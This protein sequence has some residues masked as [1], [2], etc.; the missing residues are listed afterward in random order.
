MMHRTQQSGFSLVEMV[1]YIGLVVLVFTLVL[2]IVFSFSSSYQELGAD[3][4]A[5]QS[6]L[7]SMERMV[8]D[9]HGALDYT[10]AL[11]VLNTSPGTLVLTTGATTTKFYA[12][13]GKIKVDVNG[14]YLGPLTAS[15]ALTTNLIFR[16]ST[17]TASTMVKIELTVSGTSGHV[18]KTKSYYTSAILKKS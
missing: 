5:E 17:S 4:A 9:I 13:N 2:N 6:A 14:V 15:N 8:R 3:R 1:V 10:A 16:I 7:L 12:Q 11:S 18:T